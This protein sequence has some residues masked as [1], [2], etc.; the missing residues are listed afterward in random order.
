[1]IIS[2]ISASRIKTYLQCPNKYYEQYENKVKS[3]AEHLRFGTLMHKVFERWFQENKQITEI[4]EEEWKNGTVTSLQL[5]KEAY[6]IMNI[7]E[8]KYK[9]K[10]SVVAIGYEMP[11]AI[12]IVN[13]T[14]FPTDSVDFSDK[15]QTKEFLTMLEEHNSP[16]IFGFIDRVDYDAEKDVLRILDYKTSRNPLTQLEA[17][18]DIQLSMYAL[19]ANYLFP[20]YQNVQLVLEYVRF[21]TEVKT[22][23]SKNDLELFK[24]WLIDIFYKIK[25]DTAHE[26]KL[27]AY[28]GWCEAKTVCKVYQDFINSDKEDWIDPNKM[29]DEELNNQLD[30]IGLRMKLLK[31]RKAELQD[32]FKNKIKDSEETVMSVGEFEMY[33]TPNARTSYDVRTVIN[34][35]PDRLEEVVSVNKSNVDNI[36]KGNSELQKVLEGNSSTYYI[37]PTL[38]KKRKKD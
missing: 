11:F 35:F 8:K 21:G 25:E 1:M 26:A 18:S 27:N 14:I 3:D 15:E 5:Y 38:R 23:R 10:N 7:F 34:L 13:G 36:V 6:D 31:D 12:D 29:S 19:V 4:F 16:I 17:D 33:I 20:D 37:A 9:D 28:C 24:K 30:K 22:Y 32:Y 2:Y